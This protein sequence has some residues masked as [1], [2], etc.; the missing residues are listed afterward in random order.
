MGKGELSIENPRLGRGE[1]RGK[2]RL[3]VALAYAPVLWLLEG[4]LVGRRQWLLPRFCHGGGK[5]SRA[6]A[7]PLYRLRSALSRLWMAYPEADLPILSQS[8][9]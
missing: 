4:S 5:R 3:M 7:A 8:S 1:R 2:R 6:V 9:G